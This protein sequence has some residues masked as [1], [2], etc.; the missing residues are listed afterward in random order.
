M[1]PKLT[2]Y[3]EKPHSS[4]IGKDKHYFVRY[5]IGDEED[6]KGVI[7]VTTDDTWAVY[8]TGAR[9]TVKL[10]EGPWPSALVEDALVA[11]DTAASQWYDVPDD[12]NFRRQNA[13]RY[14]APKIC[15]S[16]GATSNGGV[17]C[18]NGCGRV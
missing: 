11:A 17:W 13:G 10:A 12:L 18:P 2:E 4:L 7:Y 15:H 1:K 14:S 5:V 3:R 16:C 8:G 6:G 9:S